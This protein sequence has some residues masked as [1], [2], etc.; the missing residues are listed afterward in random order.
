MLFSKRWPK[1][2]LAYEHLLIP[3]GSETGLRLWCQCWVAQPVPAAVCRAIW[4]GSI[5]P[6][7]I[8]F[9]WSQ[10]RREQSQWTHMCALSLQLCRN[11][12]QS[13]TLVQWLPKR[14]SEPRHL[15]H[16][17]TASRPPSMLASVHLHVKIPLSWTWFLHT[18][19][20][21]IYIPRLEKTLGIAEEQE[22]RCHEVEF[23]WRESRRRVSSSTAPQALN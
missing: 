17:H 15:E 3:V 4:L 8:K 19:S 23:T 1:I 10:G 20:W 6:H 5:R 11:R 7:S 22:R 21:L 13:P 14:L 18:I 9:C 12:T 16:S 2:S